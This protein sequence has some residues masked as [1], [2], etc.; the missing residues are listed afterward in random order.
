M[1]EEFPELMSY[2]YFIEFMPEVL[3]PLTTFMKNQCANREMVLLLLIQRLYVFVQISV[4]ISTKH[5]S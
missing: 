3:I 1:K 4:L 2:N 5:L